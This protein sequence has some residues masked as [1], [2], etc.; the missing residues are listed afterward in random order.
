MQFLENF[1]RK[2]A[3][4]LDWHH[5]K[6]V[7]VSNFLKTD[8]LNVQLGEVVSV[9]PSSFSYPTML[10]GVKN[11]SGEIEE[12][13]IEVITG[14]REENSSPKREQT[15]TIKAIKRSKKI[16]VSHQ[17]LVILHCTG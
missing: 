11:S 5:P 6:E 9:I 4:Q 15:R 8:K 16:A 7:S 14:N 12:G 3:C 13:R 10:E 2:D 1:V 17:L